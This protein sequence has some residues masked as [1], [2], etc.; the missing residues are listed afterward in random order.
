MYV[1]TRMYAHSH[2]RTECT[3]TH[4]HTLTPSHPH[5]LTQNKL[6]VLKENMDKLDK[7]QKEAIMKLD[8]VM[9]QL[10]MVKDLQKQFAS[11]SVE[12]CVYV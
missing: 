2:T 4:T 9:V 1:Y 3:I 8:D 7:D 12:V 11:V 5:T 10:E 6:L